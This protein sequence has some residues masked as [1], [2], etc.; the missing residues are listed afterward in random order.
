MTNKFK[1]ELC[2]KNVICLLF[3][4]V[5]PHVVGEVLPGPLRRHVSLL[6]RK[7]VLDQVHNTT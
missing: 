1:E 7:Y 5:L 6:E 3:G 2:S 4:V